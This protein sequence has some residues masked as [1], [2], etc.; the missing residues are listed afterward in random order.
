[1]GKRADVMGEERIGHIYVLVSPKSEFVK[2]GGTDYPPNKR[3]KEINGASPYRELGPWHLAD[4]RQVTDWRKVEAHLHYAFRSL[5]VIEVSGQKELFRVAPQLVSAKL[6]GLDPELIL[7]RPTIDRMFQD[8]DCAN[9]ILKLFAFTGLLNWL[10]IQGSWTFVL[11]PNTAGGRYFTI[12]I[13]RHEVAF[14]QLPENAS[15]N[16]W[17]SI[18]MDRLIYDFSKVRDWVKQHGGR[19]PR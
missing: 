18:V 19:F 1:M 11:F 13:G 7:K 14:S 9:Y 10:D 8:N 17:H 2:I 16:F 6:S 3:I 4:F 5:L 12:N 15:V